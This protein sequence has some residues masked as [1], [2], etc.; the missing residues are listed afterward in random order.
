[1]SFSFRDLEIRVIFRRSFAI[2][3]KQFGDEWEMGALIDSRYALGFSVFYT[4]L[5]GLYPIPRILLFFS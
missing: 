5:T 1:M 2:N 3:K 4:T